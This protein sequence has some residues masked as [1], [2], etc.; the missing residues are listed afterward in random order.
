MSPAEG[1]GESPTV[2]TT[3]A[4]GVNREKD[5][6]GERVVAESC[7]P[8]DGKL[9]QASLTDRPPNGRRREPDRGL[10][11][12]GPHPETRRHGLDRLQRKH[13]TVPLATTLERGTLF[14]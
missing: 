11:P 3:T 12:P 8:S 13:S 6:R 7:R 9:G 2:A 10:E 1:G 5:D 14:T 4:N